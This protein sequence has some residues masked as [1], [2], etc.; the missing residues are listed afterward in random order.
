MSDILHSLEIN[1]NSHPADYL[2]VRLNGVSCGEYATSINGHPMCQI[3]VYEHDTKDV[4]DECTVNLN[5]DAITQL[6]HQLQIINTDIKQLL[7]QGLVT[8]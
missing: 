3:T 1:C 5:P 6:I 8:S 2:E 7:L 4:P